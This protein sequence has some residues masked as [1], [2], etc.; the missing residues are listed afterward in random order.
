M[1]P[2]SVEL[3]IARISSGPS[4]EQEQ[5]QR[6]R[7]GTANWRKT[8]TVEIELPAIVGVD[9][10]LEVSSDLQTWTYLNTVATYT[11]LVSLP[12]R[13]NRIPRR[14]YRCIGHQ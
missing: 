10:V 2:A 4:G 13:P 7:Q 1:N 11:G 6:A 14:F 5:D 9:Y 12:R 3:T 8:N